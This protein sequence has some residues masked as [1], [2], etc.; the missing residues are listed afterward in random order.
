MNK[1]IKQVIEEKFAS[2]AQQ[3]F[4]YAKANEKGKS[5]KE[6]NKWGKWAK[7]FSDKTNYD[8]IPDKVE[9]EVDEIVDA[10]GN[11]ATSKK[12]T[13]FDV[14]GVTDRWTTDKIVKA[15]TGS[16][17]RMAKVGGTTIRYWAES[18]MSKALGFDDTMAKDVD[19]D[20]AEEHF[21]GELGLDEPETEDRLSQ[22]GYD[23]KLPDDKV[24]LVENPKKFM[25]EYIES[26]L[27]KKTKYNDI[28]SKGEQSEEKDI[29]PIVLKQLKSLKNSLNSHNLTVDDILKHLK[30]NE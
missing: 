30:D 21:K 27:G 22:M 24:R 18:D 7:E 9:K 10:H 15:G 2:K 19:Y 6:K 5:K 1:F 25:E 12:P 8:E 11:I 4:F 16:M 17:G 3:R 28:V 29:N 26:I 23:K 13:D 14:S 20:D